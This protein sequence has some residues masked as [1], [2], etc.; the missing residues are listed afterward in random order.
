MG[1]NALRFKY[2]VAI[3]QNV[4]YLFLEFWTWFL[5]VLRLDILKK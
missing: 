4:Y 2:G 1:H 5:V 3:D